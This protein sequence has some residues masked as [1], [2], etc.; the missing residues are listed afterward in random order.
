MFGDDPDPTVTTERVGFGAGFVHARGVWVLCKEGQTVGQQ[1]NGRSEKG[2]RRQMVWQHATKPRRETTTTNGYEFLR[3]HA[4]AMR[5]MTW[6]EIH[7][8]NKMQNERQNPTTE[9]NIIT[10]SRKWQELELQIW[11]VTSGVLQ[12]TYLCEST[13]LLASSYAS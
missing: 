2:Q 12:S 8:M 4:Y 6:D 9:G 1:Q 11:K 3:K 13:I 10:H 5:M 7:D